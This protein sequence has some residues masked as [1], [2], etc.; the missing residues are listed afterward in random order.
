[1]VAG[2]S[3]QTSGMGN[4]VTVAMAVKVMTLKRE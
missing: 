2:G 3:P 1:M 4:S